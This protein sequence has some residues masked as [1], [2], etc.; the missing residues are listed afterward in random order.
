MKCWFRNTVGST[1]ADGRV[2]PTVTIWDA[3]TGAPLVGDYL[4]WTGTVWQKTAAAAAQWMTITAIN[5]ASGYVE[6]VFLK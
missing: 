4:G 1:R 2:V 3:T 6:G 5:T